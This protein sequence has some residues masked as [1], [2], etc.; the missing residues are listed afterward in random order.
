MFDKS[1]RDFTTEATTMTERKREVRI[2]PPGE[3]S[4]LWAHI[5]EAQTVE[6]RPPAIAS[7]EIELWLELLRLA[8][9]LPAA[10][11]RPLYVRIY[12]EPLSDGFFGGSVHASKRPENQHR[13]V[14]VGSLREALT[15]LT[16]EVRSVIDQEQ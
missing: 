13:D 15:K 1:E 5:Q 10:W 12:V 9:Q 4:S 16:D 3:G 11:A 2:N 7:E 8:E 14:R 6:G